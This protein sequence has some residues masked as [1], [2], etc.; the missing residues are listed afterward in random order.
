MGNHAA[1]KDKISSFTKG[2]CENL[3]KYLAE[4]S[5]M[6][7]FDITAVDHF[8]Y[9]LMDEKEIAGYCNVLRWFKHIRSHTADSND[10]DN[11]SLELLKEKLDAGDSFN[12]EEQINDCIHIVNSCSIINVKNGPHMPFFQTFKFSLSS[13]KLT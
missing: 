3:N 11:I 7:S 6:C 1:P 10:T 8:V 9:S 4:R 2:D 12:V 13:L 5:F